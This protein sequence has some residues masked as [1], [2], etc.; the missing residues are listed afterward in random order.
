MDNNNRQPRLKGRSR[1]IPLTVSL[2]PESHAALDTIGRGNRSLAI[3][4][5]I[6]DYHARVQLAAELLTTPQA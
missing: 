2:S 6:A 3:E 5:L 1:R 4:M